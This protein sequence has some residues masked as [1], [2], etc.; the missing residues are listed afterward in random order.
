MRYRLSRLEF[1]L[2]WERLELGEFPTILAI[3][4]H[5]DS[6]DERRSLHRVAWESLEDRGYTDRGELDGALAGWLRMLARPE[7]EV[8]ARLRLDPNGPRVRAL[9]AGAGRYAVLAVLTADEF[10]LQQIDESALP[11]SV[12][13]LLPEHATPRAR[14]VSFPAEVLD[15]AAA[16]AGESSSR[17][18][19]LLVDARIP[20]P[21]ARLV[22]SVLGNV[23]RMGQFGAACR[24]RQ[25]SGL[26]PRRRGSYAVS[27]YDT[28]DGRWQFT[29]R[30][31]GD[32]RQWSTL[33]PA[34]H[35]RLTHAVTELL[36]RTS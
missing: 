11:R 28:P 6:L 34:D 32:G 1:D 5:G 22:A 36:S 13:T 3:N 29:R 15:Q 21:D 25:H 23:V 33:A 9:A 30:A 24:E 10:T 18:E 35:G 16:R 31:S 26:G 17:L 8:D 19:S 7:R 4:S 14:S 20:R 27:F 12:V 2:C